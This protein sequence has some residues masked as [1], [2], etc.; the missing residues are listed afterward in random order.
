MTRLLMMISM[1]VLCVPQGPGFLMAQDDAA[2]APNKE[3]GKGKKDENESG[4]KE[5]KIE[6]AKAEIKPIQIY[7]SVSGRFESTVFDEIKTD[8]DSWSTLEIAELLPEGSA[9]TKGQEL[10]RFDTEK[11]DKAIAEAEFAFRNA[12]FSLADAKLEM[13]EVNKTYALEQALAER[14]WK[15]AQ[16][17]FDYYNQVRAPNKIKDL[18]FD[19]KRSGYSLEYSK[20]ELDQLEQMYTEDDLTEESEEI[21]LK[22]ARRSVESSQHYLSRTLTR[23]KREREI[24]IPREQA[25]EEDRYKRAGLEFEKSQ[26]KL[27]IRT[28]RAEIALAKA[29]FELENKKMALDKLIADRDKMIL[30]SNTNGILYYGRCVRGKWVSA[31]GS[32]NRQIEV[33]SKLPKDKCVLTVV[34]AKQLIIRAD[35][36]EKQLDGLQARMR[37]KALI[38]AAGKT[39]IPVVVKSISRIPIEGSKFDCEFVPEE[40]GNAEVMPGMTCKMSFLVYENKQAVMVPK[41]SVF[42]DDGEISHYVYVV[43]GEDTERKEVRAGLASG[44]MIEIVDG[45]AEGDEIAKKK[46]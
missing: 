27:P 9:V 29:E 23:I 24:E 39:V 12:E 34:D 36:E 8:F 40:L 17:D 21:V 3:D 10:L 4:E 2:V 28:K 19:E 31:A 18:E 32:A 1:L 42:S 30:K 33:G 44:D 45:L 16:V 6:S 5:K 15:N 41:A 25:Q 14:Q 35:V 7:E 43:K 11:I 20:D 37:G 38:K 13:D 26:I 22:R 46:P